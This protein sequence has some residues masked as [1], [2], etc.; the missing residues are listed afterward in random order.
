MRQNMQLS[1]SIFA[2]QNTVT[3]FVVI[4]TFS[5]VQLIYAGRITDVFNFLAVISTFSIVQLIYEGR[6]T[7]TFFA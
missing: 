1:G 3:L 5:I 6:N 7:K 4:S 2:G